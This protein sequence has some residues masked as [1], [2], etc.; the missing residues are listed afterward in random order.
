VYNE[1]R[2]VET[3]QDMVDNNERNSIYYSSENYSE[4]NSS[5]KHIEIIPISFEK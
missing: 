2:A 1:G 4:N 3:D 5:C